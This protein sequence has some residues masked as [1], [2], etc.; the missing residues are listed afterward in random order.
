VTLIAFNSPAK[1]PVPAFRAGVAGRFILNPFF[2]AMFSSIGC[3]SQYN[4]FTHRH[5]KFGNIIAGKF[6]TLVATRIAFFDGAVSYV[7]LLAMHET[8]VRHAPFAPDIRG[9]KIFTARQFALARNA[10]LV[11]RN[12][13]FL[14]FLIVVAVG[15]VNGADTA[16]KAAWGNKRGIRGHGTILSIV[17]TREVQ[18]IR[19]SEMIRYRLF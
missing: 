9:C 13:S 3:G 11:K 12:Q 17:D 5:G 14:Q 8:I 6:I 4:L 16:I 1:N 7:A 19:E 18:T 10:S 15:H 2:S